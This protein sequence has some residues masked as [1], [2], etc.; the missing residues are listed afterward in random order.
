LS[1]TNQIHSRS[2]RQSPFLYFF[3]IICSILLAGRKK[4]GNEIQLVSAERISTQTQSTVKAVPLCPIHRLILI[5]SRLDLF[6]HRVAS[7]V[8]LSRRCIVTLACSAF[9]LYSVVQ[10]RQGQIQIQLL[11]DRI[12]SLCLLYLPFSRLFSKQS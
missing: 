8:R 3:S 4:K 6:H 7:T 2:R 9:P 10:L 11:S 12:F 1:N 5:P